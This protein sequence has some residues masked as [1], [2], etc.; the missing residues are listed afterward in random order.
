MIHCRNNFPS[1]PYHFIPLRHDALQS[2]NFSSSLAIPH[3]LHFLWMH[4]GRNNF[5]PL[6]FSHIVHA[7]RS[8]SF[9]NVPGWSL[10]IACTFKLMFSQYSSSSSSFIYCPARWRK[11]HFS[12]LIHVVKV[13]KTVMTTLYINI[14]IHSAYCAFCHDWKLGLLVCRASASQNRR[15]RW[16]HATCCASF[17]CPE[18]RCF[19]FS[20]SWFSVDIPLFLREPGG[21]GINSLFLKTVK[22]IHFC[23][24]SK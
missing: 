8:Y 13:H 2:C 14:K 18:W 21:R 6:G 11:N 20:R 3:F 10:F 9:L 15:C 24:F 19:L 1:L 16:L 7:A 12:S 23:R 17:P 4:C 22:I 5:S